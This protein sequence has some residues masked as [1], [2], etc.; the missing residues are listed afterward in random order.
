M[1]ATVKC[2]NDGIVDVRVR[3]NCRNQTL[4]GR[5]YDLR[6]GDRVTVARKTNNPYLIRKIE[7]SK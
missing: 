6:V 3:R 2:T 4:G 5:H 7:M 1:E